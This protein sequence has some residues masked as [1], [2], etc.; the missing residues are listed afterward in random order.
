MANTIS[1]TELAALLTETGH[2]HHQ[3][4]AESDGADPEWALWYAGYIQA[5]LWDGA[6]RLPGQSELIYLLVKADREF[7]A[8]GD[9][10]PWPRY[11]AR[12]L[13]EALA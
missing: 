11:Y 5:K 4:Y 6:G 9:D 1:E 13:L 12:L 7:T 8:S 3:A 10:G 2:K